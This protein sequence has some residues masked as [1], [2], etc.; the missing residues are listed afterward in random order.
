M[1]TTE[2]DKMIIIVSNNVLS[3]NTGAAENP[4]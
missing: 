4:R 1:Q 2:I 3:E